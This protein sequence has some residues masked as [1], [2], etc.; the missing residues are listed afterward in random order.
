[1]DLCIMYTIIPL[2]GL[3]IIFINYIIVNNVHNDNPVTGML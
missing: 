1:M 2:L 3:Q